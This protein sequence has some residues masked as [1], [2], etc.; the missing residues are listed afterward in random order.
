MENKEKRTYLNIG[1]LAI[2]FYSQHNL[3]I[4]PSFFL[5]EILF[6][7]KNINV[8]EDKLKEAYAFMVTESINGC[9]YDEYT[10]DDKK[11]EDILVTLGQLFIEL[12]MYKEFPVTPKQFKDNLGLIKTNTGLSE[13]ELKKAYL[14]L[15]NQVIEFLN[16][17]S[18]TN[19]AG[20]KI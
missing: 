4:T 11:N 12:F 16:R 8:S 10:E 2:E 7:S 1:K 13:E 15:G 19:V 3:R 6:I 9:L 18:V 17:K 20:F 14:F 5:E